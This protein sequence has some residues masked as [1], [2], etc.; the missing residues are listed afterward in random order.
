[1]FFSFPCYERVNTEYQEY[2]SS[3]NTKTEAP[4]IDKEYDG[5]VHQS[6]LTFRLTVPVIAGFLH[7]RTWGIIILQGIFGILLFFYSAK[8]FRKITEDDVTALLLTLSLSFIWAGRCSYVELRGGIFDGVAL[9]F[10]V[11]AMYYKNPLLIFSGVLL[12]SFTDE[13]GFI[14]SSLVLLFW[15]FMGGFTFRKLF[16]LQT[17]AVGTAWIAYFALRYFLIHVLHFKTIVGTKLG[18]WCLVTQTSNLPGGVWTALE[19]NWIIILAALYALYQ[20]RKHFPAL[21]LAGAII[22]IMVVAMAVI[23]ITRSMAYVFPA[24]FIALLIIRHLK[25]ESM[26]SIRKMALLSTTLSF[27]YP[28]YYINGSFEALWTYPLPLYILRHLFGSGGH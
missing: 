26:E 20:A 10:L 2:W 6:K 17:I 8:L 16:N 18:V 9:F 22:V 3:M 21:L 25:S 15:G 19:G 14:A 27:L 12:A 7:L 24:L 4:F 23:D 5:D 1:M 28:A 13:R 11:F